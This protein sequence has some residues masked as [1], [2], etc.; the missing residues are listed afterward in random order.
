MKSVLVVDDDDLVRGTVSSLLQGL[1]FQVTET[2]CGKDAFK[3]VSKTLF[4]LIVTDLFMPEIDGIE[5]IL[6]IRKIHPT[7]PIV[8]MTGGG[9]LFPYGSGSLND[10]IES[11]EFFGASCVIHKPFRK[12][13]LTTTIWQ[14]VP[15]WF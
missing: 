15:E 11:A 13:A 4:D 3:L 12:D 7:I 8:L 1:D 9:K 2:A 5:L 14:A 6:K 10:M